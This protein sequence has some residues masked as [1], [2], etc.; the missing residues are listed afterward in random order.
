[1]FGMC[2]CVC[3]CVFFLKLTSEPLSW[4]WKKKLYVL[5]N[6]V[7]SMF[8][9]IFTKVSLNN[10][11]W[12]LKIGKKSFPYK[13]FKHSKISNVT[14]T[15]LKKNPYQMCFFL[16]L[17]FSVFKYW[18]CCLESHTKQALSFQVTL[19]SDLFIN[20]LKIVGPIVKT[21]L[22]FLLGAHHFVLFSFFFLSFS[23]SNKITFFYYFFLKN[24]YTY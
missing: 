13:M 24:T 9:K 12:N 14:Q 16:E 5:S 8:F 20:K 23:L 3:V 6:Q 1:M 4:N 15:F 2:V 17:Q 7:G 19:L 10:I 21:K 22:F 11:V 18:K